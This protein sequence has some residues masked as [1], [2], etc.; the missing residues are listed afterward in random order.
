M[1]HCVYTYEARHK[2]STLAVTP[3]TNEKN[4]ARQANYRATALQ[5]H[6]RNA[7]ESYA[8]QKQDIIEQNQEN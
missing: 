3:I 8:L 4:T 7:C 2:L 1:P 5:F 6:I